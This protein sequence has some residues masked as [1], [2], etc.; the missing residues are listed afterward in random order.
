MPFDQRVLIFRSLVAADKER[1]VSTDGIWLC[2]LLVKATPVLQVK[3]SVLSRSSVQS[4]PLTLLL[5]DVNMLILTKASKI[6]K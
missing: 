3:K 2:C 5:H 1:H 6:S 4:L